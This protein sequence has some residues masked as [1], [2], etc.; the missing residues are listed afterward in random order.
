[1]SAI[2]LLLT[3]RLIAAEDKAND[4]TIC[5]HPSAV[6]RAARMLEKRLPEAG[7]AVSEINGM[8]GTTRK[9]AIPLLEQLDAVGATRRVGDKRVWNRASEKTLIT[10]TSTESED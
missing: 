6:A 4:R 1:M 8:L 10:E 7:A 5:F 2:I 9:Y 3:G